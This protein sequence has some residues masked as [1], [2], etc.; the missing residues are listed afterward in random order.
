MGSIPAMGSWPS[1]P[2]LR[3]SVKGGADLDRAARVGD[4][5]HGDKDRGAPPDA[6][7]RCTDRSGTSEPVVDPAP[8]VSSRRRSVNR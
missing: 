6:R 2:S 1:A 4:S 3:G 5:S 8:P 7:G